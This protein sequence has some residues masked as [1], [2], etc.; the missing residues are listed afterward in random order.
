MILFS[1]LV[2]RVLLAKR[3]IFTKLNPVGIVFF[4]FIIVVIALLAFVA[5]QGNAD[6]HRF[7]LL[8][9]TL[10]KTP[11]RCFACIYYHPEI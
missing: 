2:R 4:V 3:A 7:V 1:F 9:N 5:S 11:A 10:K 6:S 8:K